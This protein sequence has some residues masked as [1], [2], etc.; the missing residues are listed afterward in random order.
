LFDLLGYGRVLSFWVISRTT[1]SM[2]R[3]SD[4]SKVMINIAPSHL[5]AR[6]LLSHPPI[7]IFTKEK[8]FP[9]SLYHAQAN[10]HIHTHRRTRLILS[11]H[12]V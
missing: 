2:M 12:A 6:P 7:H 4:S 8:A 10:T 1:N 9:L 3:E 5:L 11:S